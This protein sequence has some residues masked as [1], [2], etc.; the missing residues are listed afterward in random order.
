MTGFSER[1]IMEAAIGGDKESQSRVIEENTGLVKSIAKRFFGRGAEPE[2]II[3]LG[4][5]G[6]LKAIKNFDFS[7]GVKF[8]TYAVPMIAGEIKRFLR[9]DGLIKVSRSTKEM[10]QIIYHKTINYEKEKGESPSISVLSKLTGY[11]EEE[12]IFALNS[13][14]AVT[15][16][17]SMI[18]SEADSAMVNK[19]ADKSSLFEEH[20]IN[21]IML[22]DILSSL[23]PRERQ[24]I[25]LR[26]FSSM[27][28]QEVSEI[29]GVSQVQVSRIEKKVIEKLKT[30]V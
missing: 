30:M 3:Q 5:I 9:D 28:Q 7:Y 17:D 11:S 4:M 10:A 24:V 18:E 12:I 2:D 23:K 16:L 14:E 19:L 20:I 26:Y 8:S 1:A 25:T 22:T 27:T 6:L 29:I 15:S 13:T 21:K